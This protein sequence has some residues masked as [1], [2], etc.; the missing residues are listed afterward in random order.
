M[1]ALKLV[2]QDSEVEVYEEDIACAEPVDGER[3]Q[4][5]MRY[6]SVNAFLGQYFAMRRGQ[7]LVVPAARQLGPG[8]LIDVEVAIDDYG[9][10][11]LHAQVIGRWPSDRSE[12]CEVEL[13]A[14]RMTDRLVAPLIVRALG[15]RHASRML[16]H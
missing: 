5:R 7:S 13:V 10:L 15:R 14:G 12:L 4:V 2:H 9:E 8:D 3:A 1:Q 16:R 6:D 11:V